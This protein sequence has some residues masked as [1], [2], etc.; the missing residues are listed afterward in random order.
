MEALRAEKSGLDR[1]WKPLGRLLRDL[2]SILKSLGVL[3]EALGAC[4]GD[5]VYRAIQAPWRL[6]R[7]FPVQGNFAV[8]APWRLACRVHRILCTAA[9]SPGGG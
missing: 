2:S 4:T 6:Y 5:S 1:S 9:R 7:G 3:L 8:E